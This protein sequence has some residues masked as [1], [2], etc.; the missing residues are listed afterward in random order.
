VAPLLEDALMDRDPVHRQTAA[1]AIK[2]LALGLQGLG[3]EDALQHLLN[4]VWPNVYETSPHVT[5]V[6][7]RGRGGTGR[8]SLPSIALLP[9]PPSLQAVFEAVEAL[10][11]SLGPQRIFAYLVQGLFHPARRVREVHWKI[12]NN[13]VVYSA[14]ALTPV[15]PR[16]PPDTAGGPNPYARGYLDLLL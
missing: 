14:D 10:R 4:H 11:V 12:Y 15:Y 5:Q 6:R 2:H 1:W 9:S 16:L 7:G 8:E 3:C 13:A